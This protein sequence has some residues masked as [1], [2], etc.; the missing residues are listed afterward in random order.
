M[1][2]FALLLSEERDRTPDDPAAAMAAWERFHAKAG[3]AIRAGDALTPAATGVRVTGGTDAPLVTD[4][5]FAESAEVA[6]GYYI[7]EAENLDEALALARD[8]PLATFGAV[9]VWPVV[10]FREPARE[11][12]GNDWLALLLEPP[13]T[14]HTPG[15]P[16]WEAVAAR[17]G[18]FA[19]A[20]G[21]HIIGGAALHDRSTATTVRV[22]DG[23]TL[24]TDGPYVEGA[25]IATGVYL[26]AAGD[27]DEA[28]KL[29]SMIPA[30]AVE[31]RQLAGMSAL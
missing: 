27:R 3:A 28:V 20:A 12:T 21:D 31:V 8:I 11:L 13:A 16:E 23:E 1:Q 10:H 19:T 30:S 17:H 2:Y 6:C 24:I 7:F 9:E 29:A 5:P 22:R 4:G 15:T 26:L 14:A 25:E 18:D